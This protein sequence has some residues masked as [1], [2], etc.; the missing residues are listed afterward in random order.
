MRSALLVFK[1]FLVTSFWYAA[2]AKGKATPIGE[3]G[4][5]F[6]QELI[7]RSAYGDE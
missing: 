6:E 5:R 7:K 4:S 2:V 1:H 3:D